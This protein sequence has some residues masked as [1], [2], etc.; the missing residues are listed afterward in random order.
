MTPGL[1]KLK[2]AS[3]RVAVPMGLPSEMRPHIR[4]LI[5]VQATNKRRGHASALIGKVCKEADDEWFTLMLEVKPFADGATLEQLT[6]FYGK[7]GFVVF[8]TEPATLMA[9]SPQ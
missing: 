3:L 5:D 1:R 9:R 7:H 4:E 2:S 8:Q 6:K